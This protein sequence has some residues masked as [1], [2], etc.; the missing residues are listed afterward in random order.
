MA[1]KFAPLIP[2]VPGAAAGPAGAKG[3]FNFRQAWKAATAYAVGDAVT[4]EGSTYACI[5]AMTVGE[6]VTPPNVTFWAIIAEKGAGGAALE[7]K[8]VEAPN[9]KL[10]QTVAIQVAVA[11]GWVYVRGKGKAKEELAAKSILFTL[12]IAARPAVERTILMGT[13]AA[14][15]SLLNIKTTGEVETVSLLAVGKTPGFDGLGFSL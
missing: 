12:P 10:E 15:S 13:A 5:K 3:E 1:L 6:D 14:G 9:A 7:W 11:N 8:N 4:V 2:F